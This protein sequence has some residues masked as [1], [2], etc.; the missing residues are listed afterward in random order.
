[1]KFLKKREAPPEASPA[2]EPEP[3]PEPEA[4][5]AIRVVVVDDDDDLRE[6]MIMGLAAGGFDVVG[7]AVNG[8]E[9][10]DVVARAQPD[11]VMLDLHMPD[12]GGLEVLPLLRH[13]AP[14]AKFVVVSAISAT[15]MLE[16]TLDAGAAAFIEKGV[17]MRSILFHLERV[18][19]S[20]AVKVVRPYPLN[21][22][23]TTGMD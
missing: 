16:A 22:D 11:I 12:V 6:L 20:G 18:A 3:D 4:R 14:R 5:K 9:A 7:Q 8:G 13:E 21:R 2:P 1:M 17:S 23:Y 10:L 19:T 15:H